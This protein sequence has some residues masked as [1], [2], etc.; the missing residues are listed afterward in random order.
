VPRHTLYSDAFYKGDSVDNL[1]KGV[2]HVSILCLLHL[3][4]KVG[5]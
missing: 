2:F 3:F 5:N 1:E 4:E